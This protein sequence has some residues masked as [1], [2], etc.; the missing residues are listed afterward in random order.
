[1]T[2]TSSGKSLGYCL[3]DKLSPDGEILYKDRAEILQ[4]NHCF[5]NKTELTSQF[6]EVQLLNPNL[7]LPVMHI[8]LTLPRG[9]QISKGAFT[10][11]AS[12]CA[13]AMDF[14]KHQFVTI[15]HKDTP[16]QHVHVV[17]N[18]VGFDK[19]TVS[20]SFSHDR[21]A[22]FCR[23][24]E[25]KHHLRQ[26]LGPLRHR[27]REELKIPRHGIRLD[28]LKSN[29]GES[30][31]ISRNIGEFEQHMQERGYDIYRKEGRGIAFRDEKKV[32]IKG[33]EAG[34]PLKKIEATLAIDLRLRQQQSQEKERLQR[35]EHDRQ[36]RQKQQP[37]QQR[38]KQQQRQEHRHSH[39]LRIH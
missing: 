35:Q 37:Q 31:K 33:C 3:E 8:V 15:L 2:S 29:I 10:D 9:E 38:E 13:R 25:K 6:N 30:L 5:G 36:L 14:E 11:I 20:D 7:S 32:C 23:K 27:S 17:I 4:Y 16:Q 34:Y 22:D 26:E 39:R 24:A 28:L 1:M 12:D 19:Q 18:R 21:L